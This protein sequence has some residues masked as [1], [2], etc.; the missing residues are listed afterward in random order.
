MVRPLLCDTIAENFNSY[1]INMQQILLDKIPPSS[2]SAVDFMNI[3]K[4]YASLAL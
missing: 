1:F 2:K 3:P 4:T